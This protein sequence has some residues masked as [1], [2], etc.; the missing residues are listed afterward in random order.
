M[1]MVISQLNNYF[2]SQDNSAAVF[3][4][5]K[6][7]SSSAAQTQNCTAFPDRLAL[8]FKGRGNSNNQF[9]SDLVLV[10]SVSFIR[11]NG[12]DRRNG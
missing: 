1:G 10:D 3:T 4:P 7:D 6:G 8:K 12:E 5:L 11:F 2:A 9:D